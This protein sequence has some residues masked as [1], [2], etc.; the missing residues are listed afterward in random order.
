MLK[1]EFKNAVAK[2]IGYGLE[3]NG[4][5]L[6]EIISI[7]LGTKVGTQRAGYGG[8]LNDFISN[9]CDVTIIID[10]HPVT[11]TIEDDTNIYHSVDELVEEKENELKEKNAETD[12]EE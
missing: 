10:P 1:L 2:D 4:K 12:P 8:D 9:S 11:S 5:S 7:A 6:E 3:V